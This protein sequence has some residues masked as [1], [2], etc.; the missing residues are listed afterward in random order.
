MK[1][2]TRQIEALEKLA[3]HYGHKINGEKALKALRRLD[4][5]V[6]RIS[7]DVCNGDRPQNAL[8]AKVGAAKKTVLRV[9]GFLPEGLFVNTDPRGY[10]LKIDDNI[11]RTV[12]FPNGINLHRDI[13]GYAILAPE[14]EAEVVS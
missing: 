14:P 12:H 13:G 7:T 5:S 2:D 9:L 11:E 1:T 6:N 4:L 8:N 3:R 10:S